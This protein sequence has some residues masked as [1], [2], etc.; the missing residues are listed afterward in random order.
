MELETIKDWAKDWDPIIGI[1]GI[2]VSIIVSII[3]AILAAGIPKK[4]WNRRK[5]KSEVKRWAK[6][7]RAKVARKMREVAERSLKLAEEVKE[8]AREIGAEEN[9]TDPWPLVFRNMKAADMKWELEAI[10]WL[11]K[12]VGELTADTGEWLARAKKTKRR[13]M[14]R[15]LSVLYESWAAA[16]LVMVA[17]SAAEANIS[18]ILEMEEVDEEMAGTIKDEAYNMYRNVSAEH[19]EKSMEK[20]KELLAEVGIGNHVL[21]QAKRARAA[22]RV[23]DALREIKEVGSEADEVDKEIRAKGI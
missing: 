10:A 14:E 12:E 9:H 5:R 13:D 16:P 23:L 4:W 22:K 3:I 18:S 20:V 6:G 21:W 15:R 2:I 17:E 1:I 19:R 11:A 8:E 7:Q